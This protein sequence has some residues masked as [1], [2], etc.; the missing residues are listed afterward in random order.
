M[1]SIRER[2]EEFGFCFV[3]E[4]R[5]V[6]YPENTFVHEYFTAVWKGD[7]GELWYAIHN[8]TDENRQ[9]GPF[10]WLTSRDQLTPI[11][12]RLGYR[13]FKE[14]L[15]RG[16]ARVPGAQM[17]PAERQHRNQCQSLQGKV[18]RALCGLGVF[19]DGQPGNRRTS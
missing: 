2:P 3:G 16:R 18:H 8:R 6:C 17:S 15:H 10:D 1:A 13:R 7:G 11:A 5:G 12:D 4:A 9:E 19:G 14:D